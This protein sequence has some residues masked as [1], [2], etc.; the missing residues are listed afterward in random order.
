MLSHKIGPPNGSAADNALDDRS[1][2]E[3]RNLNF[4]AGKQ[5][6]SFSIP[7]KSL[8]SGFCLLGKQPLPFSAPNGQL[9]RAPV[10]L[11]M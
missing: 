8:G 10:H 6:P 4:L 3:N 7:Q 5:K 1:F 11:T 9:L 2:L